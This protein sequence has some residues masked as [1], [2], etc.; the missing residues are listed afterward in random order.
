MLGCFSGVTSSKKMPLKLN[1]NYRRYIQPS[2]RTPGLGV[3]TPWFDF[4]ALPFRNTDRKMKC[5]IH[6]ATSWL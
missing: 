4:S 1:Y 2:G 5:P 3:R 6:A